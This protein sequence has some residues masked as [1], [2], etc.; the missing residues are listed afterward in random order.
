MVFVFCYILCP[1]RQVTSKGHRYWF[2]IQVLKNHNQILDID[3]M[4]IL[5]SGTASLLEYSQEY[6]M[7]LLSL[8]NLYISW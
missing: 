5:V 8:S 4:C 2:V 7:E 3:S 6:L 1:L